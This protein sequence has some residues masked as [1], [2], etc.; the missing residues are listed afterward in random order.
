MSR[1][2]NSRLLA[3]ER[4]LWEGRP[5]EGLMSAPND[6]FFIPFS[7]FWGGFS[8]CWEAAA[9][10]SGQ[11][12]MMVWGV[13]FVLIGLYMIVGRFF[14]DA[15]LR[16][17]ITYALTDQ[18]VLIQTPD[19]FI[20]LDLAT[21]PHVEVRLLRGDRG[22]IRLGRSGGGRNAN[23]IPALD[24]VPQL[25]AIENVN[26]IFDLLEKARATRRAA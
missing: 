11:L 24:P 19:A 9:V 21:L 25:L 2:F 8:I 18:R 26:R 4:I 7:L 10:R 5:R 20:A 3:G 17:R 6:A 23:M 15:W 22:T 16:K 12:F 13:P 1:Q 14:H